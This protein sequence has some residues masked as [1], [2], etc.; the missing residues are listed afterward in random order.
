MELSK[1]VKDKLASA[2]EAWADENLAGLPSLLA[3]C[4]YF[5]LEAELI[6]KAEEIENEFRQ[7]PDVSG[8]RTEQP[9]RTA[10]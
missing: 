8:S 2:V 5:S 6:R 1:A 9:E 3:N 7:N 10:P 4:V